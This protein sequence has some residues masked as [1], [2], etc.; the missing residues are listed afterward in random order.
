M[1]FKFQLKIIRNVGDKITKLEV[2]VLGIQL[3]WEKSRTSLDN[4]FI[5]LL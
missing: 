4:K 3:R 5:V 2:C 1:N